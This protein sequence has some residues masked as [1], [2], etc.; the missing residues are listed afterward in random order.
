MLGLKTM[1]RGSTLSCKSTFTRCLIANQSRFLSTK[2]KFKDEEWSSRKEKQKK[3][4]AK[5]KSYGTYHGDGLHFG[6][7]APRTSLLMELTDRGAGVLHDVLKFFWKYDVNVSRIESRPVR[8]GEQGEKL[9]DFF[10]DFYGQ[11][12]DSNIQKLLSELRPITDKLL[13]LD[14]KEVS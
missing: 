12:S 9:F 3:Y 4:G 10:V 7:E 14:K 1:I 13:I 6:D 8:I 11:R 2:P 5:S